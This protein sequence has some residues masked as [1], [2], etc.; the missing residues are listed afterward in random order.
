MD[1]ED[2]NVIP[3]TVSVSQGDLLYA[4][5]PILIGHFN[6]DG[7]L[8]AEKSMDNYLNG[9]LTQR[10]KLGL[11]PGVI[12]SSEVL[13]DS[14]QQIKGALIVGLGDP[15]KL[16]A[17][18]LSRTV[19]QGVTNYLLA[20]K[21]NAKEIGI[22]PLIIGCG[23]GGLTIE[24]SVRAILDG[25]QLANN[26]IR[27][28]KG[29]EAG[30]ISIVE[31]VEKY[32]NRALSCYYA[33]NTLAKEKN[34]TLNKRIKTLFGLE[35]RA[36]A[37]IAD[38]WW[39]RINV[40]LV[41]EDKS[42]YLQFSTSTGGA[43]EELRQL[44]SSIDIITGL[45]NEISTSNDWSP[46]AAKAIF[47]LLIPNDFKEQLKK[48]ANI[49]WIL[50]KDTAAYPWELLHDGTTDNCPLS[51][52]A[53]MI[54]QLST[55]DYRLT[56]NAVAKKTAL[57]VADP[58]LKGFLPALPAAL[59]EGEL[60]SDILEK[61]GFVTA[62]MIQHSSFSIIK[63]LFAEDYRI[64]HLAGHGVFN[65]DTPEASGMVIGEHVYLSTREIAQM[66]TVPEL[67]FVNCCF[68]GK[69]DGAA[70][71]YYRNRY[72]LAANIGVQ[73]IEN[74]VKA[75]VVAGWAVSDDGALDFTDQFYNSMFAGYSFGE[76]IQ[77]ARKYIYDKYP[78]NNTW[79]AYQ[80]YGD[81]FYK[82]TDI[83]RK[84][85]ALLPIYTMPVEAEDALF[86]LLNRI[87]MGNRSSEDYLKRLD[88]IS[89]AVDTAG[90]R[91]AAI[92]EKEAMIYAEL[93]EYDKALLKFEA[94]MKMEKAT[95]S[96]LAAEQYCNIR[97]KKQIADFALYPEKI[98][99]LSTIL[100]AVIT[101]IDS[102][103]RLS[104]TAERYI[105][106]A[107]TVKRKA[108]LNDTDRVKILQQAAAYY[109]KATTI[110][111]SAHAVIKWL[112]IESLLVLLD[113]KDDW[114]KK[115]IGDYERPS[116]Q[117]AVQM[118]NTLQESQQAGE[119]MNYWDLISPLNVKLCLLLIHPENAGKEVLPAAKIGS[120]GKRIT[121]KAHLQ[122]L[123]AVL[124]W[125][126][127]ETAAPL[128]SAI[129]QLIKD[130]I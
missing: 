33:L 6:R 39:N 3:M 19:E 41:K 35:R 87:E 99:E 115:N 106:L 58:Q 26:K 13:T 110:I 9:V 63:S 18:Q 94:L 54:R 91:N 11:Y 89:T 69:T 82:L 65:K 44:F 126:K 123:S 88:I 4:A 15:G 130:W 20:Q 100:D 74:G 127:K 24:N 120:P 34:I 77:R 105:L 51:V 81:P 60:V 50:D 57:V 122:F 121:E 104:G 52:S 98:K 117:E 80:C 109:Y 101:D 129:D 103:A 36:F 40:Q 5:Y 7:I 38:E 97:S 112:E 85:P 66:S 55:Q 29:E 90:I 75:V 86:N 49:N 12:G 27:K 73:L 64:I 128:K 1:H 8:Y 111:H 31:F 25:I 16:T 93:G 17:Y 114:G 71:E 46:E 22:S 83:S 67:V 124:S 2:Y 23:Y 28:L 47:E 56:I 95:F 119:D 37:N 125:S 68:L 45:V 53:G 61:Q 108:L 116:Q 79:G 96:F 72:K 84:A 113:E 10:Q 62:R 59:K 76:A 21:H 78:D 102:L 107:G 48:Q 92:T 14:G 118:L 30:V 43:R 32:E 42:S 70:E